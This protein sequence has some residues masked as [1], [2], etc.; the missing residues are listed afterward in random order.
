M[1]KLAEKKY[2]WWAI[3]AVFIWPFLFLFK[4]V[5]DGQPFSEAITLDVIHFYYPKAYLLDAMSEGRIPLWSPVES[6]G[7]PFYSSPYNQVFYPFNI[8]LALYYKFTGGFSWVDYQRYAILGISL[9]AVFM[10]KWLRCLKIDWKS[11]LFATL[12]LSICFKLTVT[13]NRAPATH[14]G[15]WIMMI[16]WGM[17]V[18]AQAGRALRG[19]FYVFIASLMLF[20]NIYPYYIYYCIFL[21]PIYG[22]ALLIPK[23]R[24][25]FI[26]EKNLAL[27]KYI[28]SMGIGFALPLL[29]CAPYYWK[30]KQV[31]GTVNARGDAAASYI[32]DATFSLKDTVASLIFPVYADSRGWYYFGFV[33]LLLIVI[34][35]IN[36]VYR[37]TK[38][39]PNRTLTISA[40]VYFLFISLT[41]YGG[42]FLFHLFMAIIPGF[43]SFRAWGR[44]NLLLLFPL[45]ILL[46]KGFHV[47]YQ[48][49]FDPSSRI[50]NFSARIKR[51]CLLFGGVYL[52]LLI[53]QLA[54]LQFFE[55]SYLWQIKFLA[56]KP[57]FFNPI[58][59]VMGAIAFTILGGL[60]F[61]S[62]RLQVDKPETT[63][64][65]KMGSIA[66]P[67]GL[68][69]LTSFDVGYTPIYLR[70]HPPLEVHARELETGKQNPDFED[71]FIKS[72]DVPRNYVKNK[73]F[74]LTNI[75]RK[76]D[77]A[78]SVKPGVSWWSSSF[79]RFVEK[80]SEIVP[81]AKWRKTINYNQALQRF[82]GMEDGKKIYF[83]QK[84]NYKLNKVQQFLKENRA[85]EKKSRFRYLV[86]EY[87][88][89][90][91][92]IDVINN[93]GGYLTFVDNWTPE[94]KVKVDGEPAK[95]EVLFETFKAVHLKKGTHRVQFYYDP[96]PFTFIGNVPHDVQRATNMRTDSTGGIVEQ[97]E[98][99]KQ[100]RWN[101]LINVREDDNVLV[102]TSKKA[103]WG[104]AGAI[105]L[106]TLEAGKDGFF[107]CTIG[108]T[109][110]N[111]V[112]GWG[113]NNPN[114]HY[115]PILYAVHLT[116][117]GTLNIIEQG[118]KKKTDI[119]Y[120]TG[121][122][123]RI[124]RKEEKITY[125]RNGEA[126]YTS[127]EPSKTRLLI[128]TSFLN[129]G[130]TLYN[131]KATF[132]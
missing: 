102:C 117:K 5:I 17:T 119:G 53:I 47:F 100:V 16:I 127:T 23:T 112:I 80:N 24:E 70:S 87:N 83:T 32:T 10:Y 114:E 123:I 36:N 39:K 51:F 67:L 69:A 77:P 121:D 120:R 125:Y 18:A 109:D 99:S 63:P 64:L 28:T 94:W 26:G 71:L 62:K 20:T 129:E 2:D 14:A 44:L 84:L 11:A 15:A 42:F 48:V 104:L 27:G 58:Y 29:I 105:S 33:G 122:I 86:N 116:S 118:K 30:V 46:A 35:L 113:R 115:N 90:Y 38:E 92:D 108:E 66:I 68:L 93:F 7:F 65:L 79:T 9:F 43:A 50:E 41:T 106:N 73:Q 4:Y 126:I 61:F 132:F 59:I 21:V 56:L 81:R 37:I 88:G 124:A 75:Y 95:M 82:L 96:A 101:K 110:K 76:K 40:I 78:F 45:A 98:A 97:L 60:L 19:G 128:D 131:V 52:L 57:H 72:F 89:D 130:G 54:Y 22:L 34:F 6:C 31:Y 74:H 103:K 3:L 91:L 8:P 1:D 55:V 25:A 111:R 12:V 107:E 49:V 13:I 85:Y